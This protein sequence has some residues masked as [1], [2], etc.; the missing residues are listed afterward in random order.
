M[1]LSFHNRVTQCYP[2]AMH[3]IKDAVEHIYNLN[4]VREDSAIVCISEVN[5][6]RFDL[7][8]CNAATKKRT[9]YGKPTKRAPFRLSDWGY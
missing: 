3:T 6:G 2:V 8:P 7:T 4:I 1:K 9:R 5:A